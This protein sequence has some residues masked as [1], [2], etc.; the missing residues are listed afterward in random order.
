ME[1]TNRYEVV[2]PVFEMLAHEVSERAKRENKIGNTIQIMVKDT[3]YKA[4]NK[5]ITFQNHT[6]SSR[7]ILNYALRLYEGN[8]MDMTIRACGITLQNLIDIK[9]MKIQMTF[10]DYEMH[11]EESK[12]KLLINDLNRK[13]KGKPLKRASEVKK[14]G[15]N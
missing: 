8:F 2:K 12:T 11:M 7:D 10:F 14:N 9:E 5:S 6:N 4:H 15:N 3:Q 13:I 1:Y